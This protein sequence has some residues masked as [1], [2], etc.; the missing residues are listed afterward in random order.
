MLNCSF[1]EIRQG[2]ID[3][4]AMGEIFK[5][6][7]KRD[8]LLHRGLYSGSRIQGDVS[9]GSEPNGPQHRGVQYATE[10]EDGRVTNIES[11]SGTIVKRGKEYGP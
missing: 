10:F 5:G 9:L 7:L 11:L 3:N 1:E 6:V 2:L 8:S 4:P